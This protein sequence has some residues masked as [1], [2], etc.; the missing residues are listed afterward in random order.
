[1]KVVK[2]SVKTLCF[3][4][5]KFSDSMKSDV[6]VQKLEREPRGTYFP[7]ASLMGTKSPT[8][9]FDYENPYQHSC[10]GIEIHKIAFLASYRPN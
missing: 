5:E 3:S 4:S 1:M 7:P 9:Y 2:Q 10:W 8:Y 6:K